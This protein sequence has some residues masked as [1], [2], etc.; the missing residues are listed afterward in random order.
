MTDS[1]TE[2]ANQAAARVVAESTRDDATTP[3]QD[4]EAA[5]E[6][7]VAGIQ[8]VDDRTRSLLRAAFEAGYEAAIAKSDRM[9][10]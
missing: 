3:P 2:D 1:R 9:A 5:W 10:K 4:L 7:W 8:R 6:K